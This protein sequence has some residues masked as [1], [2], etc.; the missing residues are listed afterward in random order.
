MRKIITTLVGAGALVA[1]GAL[2]A[3]PAHSVIPTEI[4]QSRSCSDGGGVLYQARIQWNYTYIDRAGTRRAS[5]NPLQFGT[6]EDTDEAGIDNRIRVYSFHVSDGLLHKIQDRIHYEG[7]DSNTDPLTNDVQA[8]PKN[9]TDHPLHS[10]V[11][12]VLG[13]DGD[14]LGNCKVSFVEPDGLPF[15]GVI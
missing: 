11:T 7:E 10:Q 5:V 1:T 13:T 3:L 14:G 9:P 15:K 2:T 12:L 8:N 6:S 4:R